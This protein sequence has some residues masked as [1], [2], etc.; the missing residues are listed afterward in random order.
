[1]YGGLTSLPS[2]PSPSSQTQTRGRWSCHEHRGVEALPSKEAER[3]AIAEAPT[4]TVAARNGRAETLDSV[5]DETY[6]TR[7]PCFMNKHANPTIEDTLPLA[8]R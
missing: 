2:P 7:I 6:S 5:T 8:R 1:M 4:G 3:A